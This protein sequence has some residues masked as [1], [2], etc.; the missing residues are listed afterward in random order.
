[1][2]TNFPQVAATAGYDV[3]IV[4]VNNT[5]VEQAQNNIKNSLTRVAKK[6]FKDNSDDQNKFIRE[7]VERISG[8]SDLMGTVK[9]TD[10]VIE[11]IVENMGIKHKLFE[12][13]DKVL[14]L[15]FIYFLRNSECIFIKFF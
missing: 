2:F 6:Q 1:M 11:A 10:L 8:S 7:T 12:S 14:F 4:E 3:T 5:L 15:Y 9:T 13:L